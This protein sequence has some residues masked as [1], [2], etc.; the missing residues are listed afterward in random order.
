MPSP[1]GHALGGLAVAWAADLLPPRPAHRRPEGAANGRPQQPPLKLRRS[2]EAS[3]KAEGLHYKYVCLCAGLAVLPDADLLFPIA[4]RTAT[5]SVAAVAAVALMMIVASWVTGKVTARVALACVAAYASHILLDWLQADPNPPLGV[6]ALWPM[7]STWFLSGWDLL[8]P[9]E[10]RHML[11]PATMR[12]NIVAIVQE[13]VIVGPVAAAMWLVRVKA[14][15]G[16]PAEVTGRD[17]PLE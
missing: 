10:R 12:R 1:I 13:V 5:H 3:A 14:L 17:H 15:A 11:D 6:Q 7:S 8:R 16:L 2:A 4:H 9:T